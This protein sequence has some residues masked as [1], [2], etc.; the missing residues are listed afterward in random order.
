MKRKEI[1]FVSVFVLLL[2]ILW[3]LPTGYE[4][5]IY[6]NSSGVKATVRSVNNSGVYTTGLLNQG[7]QRCEIEILS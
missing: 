1:V 4:Q 6:I 2:A 7:D 3:F 5:Q